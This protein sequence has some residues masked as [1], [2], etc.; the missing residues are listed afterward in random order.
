MIHPSSTFTLCWTAFMLAVDV[1]YTAFWVPIDAAFCLLSYGDLS[2]SCTQ[3]EVAG[4][5]CH[6]SGWFMMLDV[7]CSYQAFMRVRSGATR[8]PAAMAIPSLISCPSLCTQA[9]STCSTHSC[10]FRWVWS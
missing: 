7:C 5:E 8:R 10:R 3:V 9:A 4:G 2:E 6:R 1:T